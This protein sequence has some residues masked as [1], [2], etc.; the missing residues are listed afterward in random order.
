MQISLKQFRRLCI[1]KGIYPREPKKKI[2]GSDKTYYHKKD[3]TFLEVDP[4]LAVMRSRRAWQKKIRSA[5]NKGQ[6]DVLATLKQNKPSYS[7]NHIIRERYPTFHDAL[8]DLD[9]ALCMAFMFARMNASIKIRTSIVENAA[10]LVQE[11]QHYVAATHSLRKVFL[12]SKGIYYQAELFGITVTWLV[13]YQFALVCTDQVDYAV[14]KA[15]FEFYDVLLTFVNFKLFHELGSATYPPKLTE[16]AISRQTLPKADF[17]TKAEGQKVITLPDSLKKMLKETTKKE[18]EIEVETQQALIS[19]AQKKQS[20]SFSHDELDDIID[21]IEEDGSDADDNDSDEE[22][23]SEGESEDESEDEEDDSE[24]QDSDEEDEDSEEEM[25]VVAPA[26]NKKSN[27]METEKSEKL[28]VQVIQDIL[29]NSKPGGT[30]LGGNF[31][32]KPTLQVNNTTNNTNTNASSTTKNEESEEDDMDV[33]QT[34]EV[35]LEMKKQEIF[36][37][38]FKNCTFYLG[39][40]VPN[41]SLTFIIRSFG[42]DVFT[43]NQL[44]VADQRITHHVI[45]RPKVLGQVYMTRE[46]VQPQWVYDC[47]NIRA[48]IPTHEYGVGKRLPPHL[49]PFVDDVAKGYIPDYR[50]KLEQYYEDYHGVPSGS[51]ILSAGALDGQEQEDDESDEETGYA[52]GLAREA[53]GHYD[54]G[55]KEAKPVKVG[56]AQQRAID[57]ADLKKVSIGLMP[58]KKQRYLKH[59]ELVKDK[60]TRKSNKYE[61]RKQMLQSGKAFVN[62][63]GLIEYRK[64][65][66]QPKVAKK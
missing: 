38:L 31:V 36:S 16:F 45:D 55:E 46:Y 2:Q 51:G 66:K 9:D 44:P 27:K 4:I 63:E 60:A 15:F 32:P 14:L 30:T 22:G 52:A 11:F 35:L 26:K 64:E 57:E 1:I 3:I 24:D 40:E 18:D 6:K 25:Q 53:Q 39:R 43:E 65:P 42:G 7:L 13:P 29:A 61:K 59:Q 33:F 50:K 21:E 56:K 8:R 58:Q 37:T 41:E 5:T 49:S 23:D 12:S 28:P 34:N 10:R 54:D 19:K 48:L 62:S 20:K 47:I 17:E